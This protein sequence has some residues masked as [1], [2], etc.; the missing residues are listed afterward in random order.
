MSKTQIANLKV[1][2]LPDPGPK[3][4]WRGVHR[5]ESVKTPLLL[6]LREQ[7]NSGDEVKL[8]FSRLI[9]KQPTIA[10]PLQIAEAATEILIRAGKVDGYIGI[11]KG[12]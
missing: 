11:L 5:P 2:N 8:S 9:G 3:R 12:R 1:P 4:F 6:E 7:T 10:D